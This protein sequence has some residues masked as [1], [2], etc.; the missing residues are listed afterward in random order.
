M[1]WNFLGFDGSS[2]WPV[3]WVGEAIGFADHGIMLSQH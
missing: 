2:D 3:M 1:L